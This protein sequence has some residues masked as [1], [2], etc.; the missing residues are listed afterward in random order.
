MAKG[1]YEVHEGGKIGEI[2]TRS[3]RLAAEGKPGPVIIS[4]PED[5]LSDEAGETV[6]S[7]FPLAVAH[8]GP[9]DIAAIQ[10]MIDGSEQ[11]I[12]VA[13]AMLRGTK[14][15]AALQRFAEALRI[16]GGRHLEKPGHF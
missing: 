9:S 8:H 2:V 12:I 14:G 10:A 7:P 15:A 16:P 5:V 13:G 3:L 6:P 11:P 1:I 4:L